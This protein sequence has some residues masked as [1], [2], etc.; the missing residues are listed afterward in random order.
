M[1][2]IPDVA[3]IPRDHATDALILSLG[4]IPT[5]MLSITRC[6]EYFPHVEIASFDASDNESWRDLDDGAVFPG[7]ARF[8]ED[9]G[10]VLDQESGSSS[11]EKRTLFV[12]RMAVDNDSVN[13]VNGLLIKNRTVLQVREV[14]V[15]QF[16]RDVSPSEVQVKTK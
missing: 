1:L 12:Q 2:R 16:V 6:D 4:L 10:D 15:E 9:L 7:F 5:L 11:E 13:V 3:Y 14:G 8:C